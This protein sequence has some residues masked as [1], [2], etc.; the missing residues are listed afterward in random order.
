MD[1]SNNMDE[2]QKYFAEWKVS[3]TE[4]IENNPS[5]GKKIRTKNYL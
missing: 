5:G 3:Y 1:T 4:C 2:S